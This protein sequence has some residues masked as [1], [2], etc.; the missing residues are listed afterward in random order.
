MRKRR[1][2]PHAVLLWLLAPALFWLS[3]TRPPGGDRGRAR[4]LPMTIGQFVAQADKPMAERDFE[5]LGTTDA[6]TREYRGPDGPVFLIAVFHDE[7]WKSVHA[8]DTCLRGSG[9]EV[10]ES[11]TLRLSTR[12]GDFEVG[13]YLMSKDVSDRYLSLFAYV[14]PSDFVSGSY[15]SFFLHHAPLALFRESTA[16]C[17]LRVESWVA[18]DGLEAT[19]HRCREFL[20]EVLPL[21]LERLR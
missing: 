16:G 17:L 11:S 6:I 13:R 18:D 5:L 2:L 4:A 19:E 12:A 7:N 21:I 20:A 1:L 15:W 14:A 9:M 3:V 10:V 8:P